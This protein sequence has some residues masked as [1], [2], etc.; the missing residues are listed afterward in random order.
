MPEEP[1]KLCAWIQRPCGIAPVQVHYGP[2]VVIQ[3]DVHVQAARN[4]PA[5]LEQ[6]IVVLRPCFFFEFRGEAFTRL[7]EATVFVNN[8]QLLDNMIV[9]PEKTDVSI[10]ILACLRERLPV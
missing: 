8:R 1:A 4:Q 2:E 10:R 9:K 6:V 3:C 5:C 7:C